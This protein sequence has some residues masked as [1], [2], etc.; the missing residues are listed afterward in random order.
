MPTRI[1]TAR[2]EGS[3]WAEPGGLSC[4]GSARPRAGSTDGR[5]PTTQRRA[6]KQ[7]ALEMLDVVLV[8]TNFSTIVTHRVENHGPSH[9]MQTTDDP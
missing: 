8:G 4:S 7:R 2:E 5:T 3:F 9:L 6:T 1:R